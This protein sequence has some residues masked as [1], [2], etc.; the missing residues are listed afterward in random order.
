LTNLTE[1]Y[2]EES[3]SK[4][5]PIILH[6]PHHEAVKSTTTCAVHPMYAG[7]RGE[8]DAVGVDEG[9]GSVRSRREVE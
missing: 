8:R 9:G 4:N 3:S 2:L 1:G 7:V 6:G 5:G